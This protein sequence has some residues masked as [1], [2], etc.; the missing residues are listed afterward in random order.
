MQTSLD[1]SHFELDWEHVQIS[2]SC[3]KECFVADNLSGLL[4]HK[5]LIPGRGYDTL[6][7]AHNTRQMFELRFHDLVCSILLPLARDPEKTKLN[8]KVPG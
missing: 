5:N 4:S 8:D 6:P 2:F 7:L 1:T 3:Y